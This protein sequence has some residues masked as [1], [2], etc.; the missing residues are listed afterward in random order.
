MFCVACKHYAKGS[1]ASSLSGVLT[2][3]AWKWIWLTD[4]MITGHTWR[5]TEI[6][7]MRVNGE[8][9]ALG[10]SGCKQGKQGG[11]IT[12][13]EAVFSLCLHTLEGT[14]EL[15][16]ISLKRALILLMGALPS[17]PDHLPKALLL[18][19]SPWR[20]GPQHTCFG[21]TQTFSP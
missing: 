13:S 14:G 2:E 3:L 4:K 5:R 12:V 6:T 8:K 16:G 19:P 1:T 10:K 17:W 15:S 18:T 20:L 21:G 11:Q 7:V 9:K